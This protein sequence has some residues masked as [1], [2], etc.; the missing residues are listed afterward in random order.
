MFIK[1]ALTLHTLKTNPYLLPAPAF[2][3]SYIITPTF[4]GFEAYNRRPG[5]EMQE[6][7]LRGLLSWAIHIYI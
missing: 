3:L 6:K 4:I 1:F 7:N 2:L 5:K